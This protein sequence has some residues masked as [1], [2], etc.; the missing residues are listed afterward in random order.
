MHVPPTKVFQWLAV[1]KT[2][3]KPCLAAATDRANTHMWD[4]PDIVKFCIAAHTI[5]EKAIRFQHPDYNLDR[6]QKLISSSMSRHLSTRKI[7][8][9]SM[10]VFLNNLAHRQTDKR[11]RANAFT[12]SFVGGKKHVTMS[13]MISSTRTVR[14]WKFLAHLWLGQRQLFLIS[15]FTYL[16]QLLYLVRPKYHKF[17]RK[18]LMFLMSHLV[19]Y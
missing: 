8:S 13:A 4:F 16:L 19:R 7:S 2:I 9:K 17:S 10:R 12:S 11:T 14:L 15:H 1:N 5:S 6:A 18:L 3:L